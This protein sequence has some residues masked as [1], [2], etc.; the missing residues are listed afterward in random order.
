MQILEDRWQLAVNEV[1]RELGSTPR[2]VYRDLS[3]LER[4]GVP[5]YQ[6]RRGTRAR[7]RVMAGYR[8][9]RFSV[10]LSW[11]E[12]LALSAARDLVG[13]ASGSF[14]HGFAVSALEKIRRAVPEELVKRADAMAAGLSASV[15]VTADGERGSG[16][17][18][19]RRSLGVVVHGLVD[20]EAD[21]DRGALVQ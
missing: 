3:V 10:T 15:G 16:H 20:R 6:E 5:I 19:L 2:T 13:G 8:S 14:F 18:A 12:M 9:R 17:L 7:C 1:A 11:P 4:I 21:G